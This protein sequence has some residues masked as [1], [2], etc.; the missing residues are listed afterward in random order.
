MMTMPRANAQTATQGTAVVAGSVLTDSTER[1]IVGAEI[2]LGDS[3]VA[4]SDEKGEFSITAVKPGS[5]KLVVRAVGY[6]PFTTPVTLVAGQRFEA[7]LLLSRAPT[8]LAAVETSTDAATRA[9]WRDG[10]DERRRIGIGHFIDEKVMTRTPERWAQAIVGLVP[11]L[12][13][14][15]YSGR[16]SFASTR[17]VISFRNSPS[18][19]AFDKAQGAPVACY[20]QIVIDDLVRYSSAVGEPLLDI[21]QIELGSIAAAEFYTPSTVPTR[22]NRGGNAPCGTLVLWRFRP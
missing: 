19:D 15:M 9:R 6:H 16:Q 2:S 1:P 8:Q 13:V 18:G 22:F 17:G 10:F 3:V 12:R 7:D 21:T 5:Y 20:V 11:G 14:I 4:R